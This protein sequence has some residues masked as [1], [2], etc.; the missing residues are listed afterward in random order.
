MTA[1][2]KCNLKNLEWTTLL[3]AKTIFKRDSTSL[4]RGRVKHKQKAD[5]RLARHR[6]A[7]RAYFWKGT[8]SLIKCRRN[9]VLGR[10][11]AG[12][13]KPRRL[14]APRRAERLCAARLSVRYRNCLGVHSRADS[15]HPVLGMHDFRWAPQ[16]PPLSKN[17]RP[18]YLPGTTRE[19][20]E[21]EL[22]IRLK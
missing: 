21:Y 19:H 14:A 13:C 5:L 11:G 16:L 22:V 6:P 12:A 18:A 3:N 17:T 10:D 2:L 8:I 15:S 20:H 4:F 7:I 9:A 1:T